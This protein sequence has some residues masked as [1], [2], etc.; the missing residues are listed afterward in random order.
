MKKFTSKSQKIG[1]IGENLACKY[2]QNKG[3]SICERNYT[4]KW[5]EIDVIAIKSGIT[6]FFEV[7]SVSCESFP[8]NTVKK[9]GFYDPR[10]I[11][12]RYRPEDQVGPQ[13][14]KRLIK[15]IKTYINQNEIGDWQFDVLCIFLNHGIKKARI[16]MIPDV[17]LGS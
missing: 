12:D 4:K 16:F 8:S 14:Q 2:L 17:I 9:S 11:Y 10:F 15:T 1:E 7:K 13:K 6:H 5:G 3:F